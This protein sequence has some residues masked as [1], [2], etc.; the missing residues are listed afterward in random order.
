MPCC[1]VAELLYL[2]QTTSGLYTK[3]Y[4]IIQ[5]LASVLAA[6]TLVLQG[7]IQSCKRGQRG[8]YSAQSSPGKEG[9]KWVFESNL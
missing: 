4:G 3:K 7:S 2:K 8:L 5:S 9:A 6:V 1:A